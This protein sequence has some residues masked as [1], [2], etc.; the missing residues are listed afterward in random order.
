M[1]KE[2]RQEAQ[3]RRRECILQVIALTTALL[4]LA[5]AVIYLITALCR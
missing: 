1:R 2:R 5:T 4:N 3:R